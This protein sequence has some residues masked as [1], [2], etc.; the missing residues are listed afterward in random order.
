MFYLFNYLVPYSMKLEEF[1]A[2]VAETEVVWVLEKE[3]SYATATSLE[4]EDDEGEPVEVLCFWSEESMAAVCTKD[5]WDGYVPV[6]IP[7]GDFLENWCIGM[8]NDMILAGIDFDEELLGDELDPLELILAIGGALF[9]QEKKIILPSS[10]TL[11]N[12]MKEVSNVLE[13]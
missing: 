6:E 4:F 1:V 13:A 3:D 9:A 8:D 5:D 12:L 10:K 2:K 11:E 7:V